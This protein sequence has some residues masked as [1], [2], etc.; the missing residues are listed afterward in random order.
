M[1][2]EFFGTIANFTNIDT[3]DLKGVTVT[4]DTFS[5]GVL[6]LKDGHQTVA[7]LR[8]AGNYSTS[9]FV[10]QVVGGDTLIKHA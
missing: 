8:F 2:R 1:P 7:N 5:D 9:D 3:I 6:T 4:S 10:T